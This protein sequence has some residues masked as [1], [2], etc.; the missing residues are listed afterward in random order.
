MA[1]HTEKTPARRR[2]KIFEVEANV[3]YLEDVIAHAS[4]S[5]DVHDQADPNRVGTRDGRRRLR[6]EFDAIWHGR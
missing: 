2:V 3:P 5:G 1:K 4:L 6:R